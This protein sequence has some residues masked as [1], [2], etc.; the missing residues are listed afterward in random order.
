MPRT[1][2][3]GGQQQVDGEKA[4]LDA[5]T[6]PGFDPRRAAV[7]ENAVCRS[8]RRG[9]GPARL[10]ADRPTTGPERVV[11]PTAECLHRRGLVVLSD[12]WFPGWKATVDG[13]DVPIERVDYLL[14]GVVGGSVRWSIR[15]EMRDQPWELGLVGR[16]VS[17][18]TVAAARSPPCGKSARR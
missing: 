7:V 13:R 10:V 2:V 3:V 15:I 4:A 18:L 6:A 17:L 1:W 9:R 8:R 11:L 14:R 12:V 16:I 5:I